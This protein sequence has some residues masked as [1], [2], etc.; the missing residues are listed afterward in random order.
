MTTQ[1]GDDRW[2]NNIF[3]K[4][5]A[6]PYD[7]FENAKRPKRE[8]G[9]MDFG[10]SIYDNYPAMLSEPNFAIGEMSNVKLPVKAENNLYLN[11]AI[12]SKNGVNEKEINN[13]DNDLRV[14]EKEDGTY[15]FWKVSYDFAKT[16]SK[17]IN[18]SS[19]GEA[20]VPGAVFDNEDGS[21]VL[22]SDDY[23]NNSRERN[24]NKAGPFTNLGFGDNKLKLWPK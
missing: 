21:P 20:L 23:F 2:I 10:L 18:S 22:F 17:I 24:S 12:P 15:L 9:M 14:E 3:V 5:P 1:G 13:S 19:F 16:E 6:P 11:G 8:K 4:R 7:I